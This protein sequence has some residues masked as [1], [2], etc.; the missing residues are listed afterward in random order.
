MAALSAGPSGATR[1]FF[2]VD[3]EQKYQR[4]GITFT[5]LVPSLAMRTRR[6]LRRS[7]SAILRSGS[8]A[9][10]N[11]NMVGAPQTPTSS[12]MVPAIRY[13]RTPT[14]ARRQGTNCSKIPSNLINSVGQA[15][16]NIYPAPNANQG[17]PSASYNY[18]NEPVRSLNETKFD[19]R[20]DETLT[21]SDNLFARFSYDQAF[22]FVPGGA[23]TLA[24]SNAFGSNENLINHGRNI[25]IGWS[26]VFSPTHAQPGHRGLRPHLRLHRLAG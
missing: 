8:L 26:H 11:P 23:P 17:S 9:I 16:I 1:L 21:S 14:A 6:L 5:G 13:P 24:E 4:E 15:M 20:L 12:A 22:S 7:A 18:V 19:A 10:A 25:G 2:F 3:G